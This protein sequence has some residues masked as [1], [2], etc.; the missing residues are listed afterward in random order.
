M[1][2][3]RPAPCRNSLS[4]MRRSFLHAAKRAKLREQG[5]VLDSQRQAL[6]SERETSKIC[7]GVE[8]GSSL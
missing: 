4:D 3:E 1:S 5:A 8:D 2:F 7:E 6:D